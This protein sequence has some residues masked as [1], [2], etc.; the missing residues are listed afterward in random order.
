M[1]S[2]VHRAREFQYEERMLMKYTDQA[3]WYTGKIQVDQHKD[4]WKRWVVR[5]ESYWI[6]KNGGMNSLPLNKATTRVTTA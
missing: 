1:Y 6:K 5:K 4:V 3:L 2:P